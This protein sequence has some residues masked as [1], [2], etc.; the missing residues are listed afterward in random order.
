MHEIASLATYNF[1]RL[2]SP[3]GPLFMPSVKTSANNPYQISGSRVAKD[4]D[5]EI[6]P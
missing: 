4:T 2:A 5:Q 1:P 3:L 6:G